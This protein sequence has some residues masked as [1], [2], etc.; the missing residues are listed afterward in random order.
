[1]LYIDEI[2]KTV[3]KLAAVQFLITFQ[4]RLGQRCSHVG[5]LLLTLQDVNTNGPDSLACTSKLCNW[6]VPRGRLSEPLP[7]NKL[8]QETA[9]GIIKILMYIVTEKSTVR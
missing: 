9:T 5:A 7:F 3:S 1:V 8:Q 6:T 2:D 4:Y